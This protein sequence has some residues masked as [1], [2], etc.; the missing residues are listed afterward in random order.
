MAE[1]ASLVGQ[2]ERAAQLFGTVEAV[3]E[4]HHIELAA[5]R[6]TAYDRTVASI[7]AHLDDAA[8]VEAWARGRAMPLDQAIEEALET[9]DEPLIGTTFQQTNEQETASSVPPRTS[10]SQPSPA[11]SPR[12]ALQQQ[13]GGLTA[14]E[15]EVARLVAQGKSNR[16]IAEELVVGVSTVEAHI[17]HIF[18][19]LGFSSRAQIGAWAVD[20][21]LAQVPQDAEVKRQQH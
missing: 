21:G 19:K 13:F 16:A 7:R 1:V 4:A 5:L 6:R 20:K 12:R 18:T 10:S 9:K 14:R 8:F 17:T 2:P 3:R 11:L 15:R